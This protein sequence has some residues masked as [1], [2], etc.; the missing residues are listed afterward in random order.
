MDRSESYSGNG[1]PIGAE[2]GAAMYRAK[3]KA[4]TVDIMYGLSGRDVK[5]EEI[6]GIYENLE[7]MAKGELKYDNYYYLGLRE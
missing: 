4:E 3:C 6:V 7:K 5:V 2:L 1:G